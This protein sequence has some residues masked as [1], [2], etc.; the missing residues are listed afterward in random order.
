MSA[1]SIAARQ[2]FPMLTPMKSR[3]CSDSKGN[4][5]RIK[6]ISPHCSANRDSNGDINHFQ[7]S[8]R[9]WTHSRPY[10]DRETKTLEFQSSP[11]NAIRRFDQNGNEYWSAR[12]LGR[13]LGYVTNYRNFQKSIKKAEKACEE[14]G[15]SV[16]DHF[17]HTRTMLSIGSGAKR[18]GDDIHLSRYAC[19]LIIQN[20]D[21]D[22]PIVAH[23]QTYFAVQTRRQELT[24]ERLG[25][26]ETEGER[27]LRL[28]GQLRGTNT[29]LKG[30][31][32]KA[33]AKNKQDYAA[34]FDSG[35][36][37]LYGGETENDIH[38]RKSL[39]PNQ[40][41]LDYMGSDELSYNDFRATLTKQKLEREQP[42]SK[43]Q[44]NDAHYEMGKAVRKTIVETGAILPENLPTPEK[45]IQQLEKERELEIQKFLRRK[46]QPRL[47]MF[48]ESEE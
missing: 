37:G 3:P 25:L 33:G 47:P 32:K 44:A 42:S 24:D 11:F 8:R 40:Q 28:R 23:G 36:K 12:E 22:K 27:R 4:D 46:E 29:Q 41:I 13:V 15:H 35:H 7:L 16:I 48:S 10:L 45:S 18:E 38:E 20:A 5:Y 30:Q 21:P 2:I 9:E 14:S 19:Y 1:H 26:P 39:Q 31:V 17:A 34:F 6:T 43:E